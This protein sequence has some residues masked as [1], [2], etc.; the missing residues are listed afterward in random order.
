MSSYNPLVSGLC[1]YCRSS[2][3]YEAENKAAYCPVCRSNIPTM[4]LT[5]AISSDEKEINNGEA[6]RIANNITSAAGG[7]VYLDNFTDSCNWS[8]F[9][10]TES[11]THPLLDALAAVSEIKFATDP[12]AYLL[13]FRARAI[14]ILK[15]IE[16]LSLIELEITEN[17][18]SDDL[19]DAFAYTD[20]YKRL[21]ERIVNEREGIIRTL[22]RTL[23]LA[24]RFNIDLTLYSDLEK[25]LRVCREKLMSVSVPKDID[26]VQGIEHAKE[27]RRGEVAEKY[28]QKGIDA[29]NTYKKAKELIGNGYPGSALHLLLAIRG[30]RDTDKLIEKYSGIFEFNSEIIEACGKAYYVKESTAYYDPRSTDAATAAKRG[31][32]LYEIVDGVPAQSPALT[33]I[34]ELI[35][36]FGNNVYFLRADS[37]ICAFDTASESTQSVKLLDEAPRGD[38][39]A[40]RDEIYFTQDRSKFVLRKKLRSAP[41]TKSGCFKR[42]K[43]ASLANRKNNYSVILVD[44]DAATATTVLP[45]V[46][47]I[48]DFCNGRIF[49]TVVNAEGK[50]VFRTYDVATGDD[51][52]VLNSHCIINYAEGDMIVYSRWAPT[53]YNLDL[54]T[55]NLGN[56]RVK[57]V[58]TN[59]RSFYTVADGRIYYTVGTEG[60]EHLMSAK[61][62]GS[63]KRDIIDDP[64]KIV[65]TN[66]GWLYYAVG[67]GLN[68][69]LM[70]VRLTGEDKC[71]VASSFKSAV[72]IGGGHIYYLSTLGDLISVRTD[73]KGATT[74]ARGVDGESIIVDDKRVYYLKRD[75]VAPA[76]EN[77][78]GMGYSL[79]ATA[80]D[81][82]DLVKLAHDVVSIKNH[83]DE[84]IYVCRRPEIAYKIEKP[85]G[86]TEFEV[87]K[88]TKTISI[89]S[90]FDKS[91]A[92]TEEIVR[93][94]VPTAAGMSYKSGCFL[95]PKYIT[96]DAVITE[97]HADYKRTGVAESGLV[98]G[99]ELLAAEQ[100]REAMESR[101]K[102]RRTKPEPKTEA[103]RPAEDV[104]EATEVDTNENNANEGTEE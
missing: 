60:C 78:D 35:Y 17:F 5:P 64:G 91:S 94:G 37:A 59:I 16:G 104:L 49:Y 33:G 57:T 3:M 47:D 79:F 61:F 80:L 88:I 40:S 50:T 48:M 70:K 97:L 81:G 12:L 7:L 66:S 99:E 67:T 56:Y 76:T 83:G 29:E 53:S 102:S 24:G 54:Y 72:K 36:A 11:L 100:E 18:K 41:D 44:M 10:H 27:L 62:D 13:S 84:S 34:T 28:R 46:V 55:L 73:G 2:L 9:V 85:V 63:D 75:R 52:A 19:S 8:E 26:S 95:R 23:E 96:R 90:R 69:V 51:S 32:S 25:S 14:P 30:Y 86:K 15:K 20:L 71:I 77:S 58:A 103:A 21:T 101:K 82:T 87:E 22:E 42:K 45:E 39:L 93:I 98:E 31:C 89:Y 65:A 1:P 4:H 92:V 43:K 68:T 6:H 38:Y 74:V